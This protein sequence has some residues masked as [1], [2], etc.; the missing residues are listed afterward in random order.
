MYDLSYDNLWL[1]KFRTGTVC[2]LFRPKNAAEIEKKGETLSSR[3][4]HG[5]ILCHPSFCHPVMRWQSSTHPVI[6]S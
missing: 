6:M 2:I 5:I 1:G 4:I 3:T